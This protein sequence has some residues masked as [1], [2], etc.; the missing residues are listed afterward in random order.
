MLVAVTAAKE[1]GEWHKI[2]QKAADKIIIKEECISTV[3]R[4]GHRRSA[5]K[6][7]SWQQ[8]LQWRSGS[9]PH[10][11]VLGNEERG[12]SKDTTKSCWV[13]AEGDVSWGGCEFL[14]VYRSWWEPPER[15]CGWNGPSQR[16]KF[17]TQARE[18]K[19]RSFLE[20]LRE[21]RLQRL[22][23]ISF[24]RKKGHKHRMT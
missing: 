24:N 11:D 21:V 3:E 14:E 13:W 19:R 23:R 22:R 15:G 9:Q 5:G 1:T 16:K 20:R 2:C 10:Y 4:K 17:T 18:E 12:K 7:W 6:W 8:Q